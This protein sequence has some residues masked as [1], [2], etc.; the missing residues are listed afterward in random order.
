MYVSFAR[1]HPG[2][3]K[4]HILISLTIYALLTTKV[5]YENPQSASNTMLSLTN[6]ILI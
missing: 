5:I 2:V 3:P 1:N 4:P 6:I